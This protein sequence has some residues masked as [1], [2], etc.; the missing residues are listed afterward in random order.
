MKDIVNQF[1]YFHYE[2][3]KRH[4]RDDPHEYAYYSTS[5]VLMFYLVSITLLIDFSTTITIGFSLID[6]ISGHKYF[7]L[8]LIP[9]SA[10]FAPLIVIGNRKYRENIV[11]SMESSDCANK[12]PG[13]VATILPFPISMSLLYLLAF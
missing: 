2:F 10:L 4:T 9:F 7:A 6:F 13:L 11:L 8:A 1:Y 5:A 3:H 12:I